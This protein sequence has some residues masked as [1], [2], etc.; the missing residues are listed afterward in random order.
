MQANTFPDLL[1]LLYD[2]LLDPERWH[3]FVAEV[4]RQLECTKVS[5]TLHDDSNQTP[6]VAFS[7]GFSPDEMEAFTKRFGR[8]NPRAPEVI[9]AVARTG[10]YFGT[11]NL[12]QIPVRFR[13]SEY[14]EFLRR[15]DACVFR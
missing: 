15:S 13:G 6:A 3:D 1:G 9:R 10:S 12:S 7:V 14:I 4:Q 2:G 11:G 5:I 8:I